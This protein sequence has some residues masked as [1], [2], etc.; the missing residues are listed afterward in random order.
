MDKIEDLPRGQILGVA[1]FSETFW[2]DQ[3]KHFDN[4]WNLGPFCYKIID[5]FRF[6]HGIDA[7]GQLGIWTPKDEAYDGI[8]SQPGYTAKIDEWR[9]RCGDKLSCSFLFHT[10]S[11]N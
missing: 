7:N 10:A 2:F 1:I 9:Q 8:V 11:K 4:E 5:V 6:E 3:S